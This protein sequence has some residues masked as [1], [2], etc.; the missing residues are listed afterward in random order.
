MTLDDYTTEIDD[1][2]CQRVVLIVPALQLTV[3][4]QTMAESRTLV[5]AAIEFGSLRMGQ[6]EPDQGCDGTT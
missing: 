3:L 6:A 2:D 4:G 5:S 1:T